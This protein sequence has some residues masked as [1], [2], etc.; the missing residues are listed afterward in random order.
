MDDELLDEENGVNR[1]VALMDPQLLAD[2]MAQRTRRFEP[3]LSI[4]EMD[5]LTFPGRRTIVTTL[6]SLDWC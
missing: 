5:E 3:D 1:A 2:H 6:L 4:V